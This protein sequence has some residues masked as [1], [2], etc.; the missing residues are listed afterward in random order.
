MTSDM[1]LGGSGRGGGPDASYGFREW[2]SDS[3]QAPRDC[4]R[5]GKTELPPRLEGPVV[6]C[7]HQQLLPNHPAHSSTLP[8]NYLYSHAFL[9]VFAYDGCIL[10]VC[11]Q[12]YGVAVGRL[13]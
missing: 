12:K 1:Y 11:R 6:V 3:G 5:L 2:G 4:R 10:G 8:A 13:E 9:I 7:Q